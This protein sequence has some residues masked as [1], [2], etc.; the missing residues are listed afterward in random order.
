MI[1]TDYSLAAGSFGNPV[2]VSSRVRD[3]IFRGGVNYRF[4]GNSSYSEPVYNWSGLY[5]GANAGSVIS[6]NRSSHA[7]VPDINQYTEVFSLVPGGFEGGLQIGYNWQSSA[8]VFGLEADIQGTSAKDDRTC[9]SRCVGSFSMAYIQKV[10]YVGTAR[11]RLGY[12]VGSTLFYATAGYAYGQTKT[13]IAEKTFIEQ[14]TLSLKHNKGG[15]VVGGG[16]ESPLSLFGLFGTGWTVKSEYLFV[17]LGH[18]EDTFVVLRG[19]FIGPGIDVP[20]TRTQE[21]ISRVGINYHFNTP[22]AAKF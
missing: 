7:F 14:R 21:H 22:V 12:S 2:T 10:P 18:T 6:R 4:G 19:V 17:D 5:I 1:S 8:W 15:Y 20:T 3:N 9:I 11:G 13:T 16:I